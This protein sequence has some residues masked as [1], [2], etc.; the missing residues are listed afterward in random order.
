M[1][2]APHETQKVAVVTGATR[3]LGRAIAV[4]LGRQGVEIVASGRDAEA[5][6]D[7][8]D[9][10]ARSGGRAI[11]VPADLE[12]KGETDSLATAAVARF[13]RIDIV[14]A[15]AG[16]N[17]AAQGYFE[18]VDLAEAGVQVSRTIQVKLNPVQS[19]LPHLIAGGAGS[20]L[21]VTSEGGRFPT[22]GQLTV[23]LHSG[24]L[25][26]ASGVLAKELSRHKIRVNT[27]CVSLVEDTPTWER[28]TGGEMTEQRQRMFG[29]ITEK[30]P[31]GI[32]H[33]ADV[34]EVA[35]FLVSDEARFITGA[36]ISATGGLT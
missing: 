23:G 9:Q 15:S 10:I 19:C 29:K 30:A 21:F 33:A 20:I 7:V 34:G 25:I 36:T 4:E 14:V 12:N 8:V 17:P 22:P 11:F 2:Q 18:G 32:A 35:T 28:F 3:G 27:L 13:G 31:L 16:L 5:G 26:Q 1:V 24:G 6:Y